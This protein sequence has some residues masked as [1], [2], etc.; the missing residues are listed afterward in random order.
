[1]SDDFTRVKV[2][3]SWEPGTLDATRKAI[4]P[5]DKE[6]AVRM[7]KILGGQILQE[8]S[9]PIDYSAFPPKEK[10]Y[11]RR[12]SGRSASDVASI[13][14]SSSSSSQAENQKSQKN[15][16]VG[17]AVVSARRKNTE[18]GLPEIPQK[19]RNLMDKL[20]MSDDYKIKPN[21]GIFNFVRYLKKNGTELLRHDYIIYDLQSHLDHFQLFVT[22]VKSI[23]QISPDTYKS[24][25]VN[26]PSPKFKFLRTAGGWTMKNLKLLVLDVQDHP[27][28]VTVAMMIPIVKC[29]YKDIL[30]IYYIGENAIPKFF[31]EI[32][33]DLMKY[34]NA[35]Q[36]K[37]VMLS[38]Q[39]IT[40][41][42]YVYTQIIKGMYPLLMRMCSPKFEYFPTFF[43]TET[44][45]IF[46]F[47]GISKFDLILPVKKEDV[48]I[49]QKK[50]E[51]DRK[52]KEEERIKNKP[53]N[54]R[55]KKTEIVDAGFKILDK[56]FPDAGFTHL[57][58][59]PDMYPY[60]QPIYEFPDGYNLLNPKNPL[61]ITIT[62]LRILEDVFHGCR[63]MIFT[64]ED[65]GSSSSKNKDKLSTAL[66]EWSVYREELFDKQ[67]ATTLKDFVNQEYTSGDFKSS[68]FGKKMLTTMLWQTKFNFLPH[69]EFEQL[70]LEKPR[71]DVKYISLFMRTDFLRKIFTNMS[72]DI[73]KAY[74]N[75]SL[76]MGISNP[77]AK[78]EFDIPNPISKRLDVIL[79]KKS[80][81][82]TN[83]TNANLIKYA[84]C[85]MSVLDWWINNPESP[86]YSA[87]AQKIY[88]ISETDGGPA[89]SVP[90]RTDQNKLFAES[91][92]ASAA[93]KQDKE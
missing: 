4:G 23:I 12:A 42:L 71:N 93:E 48:Q 18:T 31:K 29:L 37:L 34:P 7:Q 32:Y 87:E 9:A 79:G 92:K 3:Q 83:A 52:Q 57:E 26:D 88:R 78:Y 56:L 13:S 54:Q 90:V 85:I 8:K 45:N 24:K 47:L 66:N 36:Q 20:M 60:F 73:D 33:A 59:L 6:E 38:K 86:A 55:G 65:D 19:E 74:A 35:D 1:M 51:E 11:S 39:G 82:E 63:S 41:W 68:L 70:L 28:E 69:F 62:L 67:Y 84:M 76:V 16:K 27:D 30:K 72:K 89:F 40:E 81:G 10:S 25:I 64:E 5:V 15:S 77:W 21:F 75:K 14:S 61:Q 49:A 43:T 50:A 53:E 58:S 46:S 44:A 80:A 2:E 91:I 22:T 17:Y